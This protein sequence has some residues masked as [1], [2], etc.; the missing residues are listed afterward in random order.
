MR[1]RVILQEDFQNRDTPLTCR[2]LHEVLRNHAAEQHAQRG[3]HLLATLFRDDV[4]DAVDRLRRGVR[5]QGSDHQY[6]RLRRL[7]SEPDRLQIAHLADDEH[8]GRFSQGAAQRGREGL[9]VLADLPLSDHR[10]HVVVQVFERV[11]DA[12]D[13]LLRSLVDLVDHRGQRR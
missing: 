8:V 3:A 6:A 13:V 4:D 12:D 1:N 5:V 2:V 7:D 11:L 9:R 10:A